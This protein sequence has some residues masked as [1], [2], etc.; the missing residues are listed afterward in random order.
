M[1]L[2]TYSQLL[3]AIGDYSVRTD[4][5]AR[6][7]E[8]VALAEAQLNRS[9]RVGA[10]ITRLSLSVSTEYSPAPADLLAV[11][12]LVLTGS[13]VARLDWVP[14]E[15]M[16]EL[17][18]RWPTG[19]RPR[20]YSIV[21]AE[22]RLLSAPDQAYALELSYYKRLPPLAD[23]GANWLLSASPD[24]YLYGALVHLG[25]LTQDER[26]AAWSEA[27]QRAVSD[28]QAAEIGDGS[29]QLLTPLAAAPA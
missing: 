3:T 21:G 4:M 17:K 18:A 7:P 28:L 11:R 19:G 8:F 6:A 15:R 27:F 1:P 16:D 5:A 2:A 26:L 13:P 29:A 22:L 14:P 23:N 9:L 24:A 12:S 10:M 20:A 25:V